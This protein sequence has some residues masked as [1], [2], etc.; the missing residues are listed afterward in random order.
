MSNSIFEVFVMLLVF[1][2]I[3]LLMDLLYSKKV[4]QMENKIRRLNF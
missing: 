1:I 3:K 2:Y 4:I